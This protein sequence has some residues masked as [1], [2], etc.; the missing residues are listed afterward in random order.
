MDLEDVVEQAAVALDGVPK[1]W[2][3]APPGEQ[4]GALRRSRRVSQRHL[5]EVSGVD[6][7]DISRMEAGADA[8]LSTWLKLFS[9]LGFDAVLMP[10]VNCE[11]TQDLLERETIEREERKL[12]GRTWMGWSFRPDERMAAYRPSY[13]DPQE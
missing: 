10:L 3:E 5:A 9:A 13:L 1:R 11:D 7:A 4:L 8:R 6:Q 12:A 2:R